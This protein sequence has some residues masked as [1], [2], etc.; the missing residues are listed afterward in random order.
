MTCAK[1]AAAR[2]PGS[3]R[4]KPARADGSTNRGN[5]LVLR[6]TRGAQRS[7]N[8]IALV[9]AAPGTPAL[10]AVPWSARAGAGFDEQQST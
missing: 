2:N 5:L 6:K 8:G 3:G 4:Y 9:S 7:L 10:S 1:P